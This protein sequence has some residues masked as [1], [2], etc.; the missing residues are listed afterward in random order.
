[1]DG[2]KDQQPKIACL[3]G[4]ISNP[5]GSQGRL[6]NARRAPIGGVREAHRREICKMVELSG[7]SSKRLHQGRAC[8]PGGQPAPAEDMAKR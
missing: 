5:K 6:A 2:L 1:M 8:G 7:V 3:E 4:E